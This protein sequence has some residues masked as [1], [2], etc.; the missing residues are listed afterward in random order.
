MSEKPKVTF[1]SE[2]TFNRRMLYVAIGLGVI[3]LIVN[4]LLGPRK[5]VIGATVDVKELDSGFILKARV[6]TGASISSLHCKQ[7]VI[8]D[9]GA[10][11][12][13]TTQ[14]AVST[15]K[16]DGVRG[17]AESGSVGQVRGRRRG[18]SGGHHDAFA[19][20]ARKD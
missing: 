18:N 17:R 9:D 19:Q 5:V 14:H 12:L 15:A 6:D 7:I 8:D 4:S 20:V 10:C 11:I 13:S 1:R 3:S 16:E 2:F